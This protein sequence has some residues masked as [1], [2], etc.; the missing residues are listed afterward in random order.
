MKSSHVSVR[1]YYQ[2]DDRDEQ[3]SIDEKV[4]ATDLNDFDEEGSDG[5]RQHKGNQCLFDCVLHEET[6]RLGESR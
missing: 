6:D 4:V 2:R 1:R 3:P 5:Q